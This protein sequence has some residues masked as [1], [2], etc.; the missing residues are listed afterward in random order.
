MQKPGGDKGSELH[1]IRDSVD[2]GQR[3]QSGAPGGAPPSTFWGS[4]S[5]GLALL[6]RSSLGGR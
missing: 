4:I 3:T 5:R 6:G 2:Q 1:E